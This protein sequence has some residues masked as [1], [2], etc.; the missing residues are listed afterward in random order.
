MCF[1]CGFGCGVGGVLFFGGGGGGG[2]GYCFRIPL[3]VPAIAIKHYWFALGPFVRRHN[4]QR[5]VHSDHSVLIQTCNVDVS[6]L[7]GYC[8]V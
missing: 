6:V 7:L 4:C 1:L 3:E 8:A 5:Q 2:G